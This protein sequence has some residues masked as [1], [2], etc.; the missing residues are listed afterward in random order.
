MN[1]QHTAAQGCAFGAGSNIRDDT[2]IDIVISSDLRS[3]QGDICCGLIHVQSAGGYGAARGSN[4][5]CCIGA[6]CVYF[7][8]ITGVGLVSENRFRAV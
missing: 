7:I 6:G 2:D 5:R 1:S 8:G 3:S 4:A